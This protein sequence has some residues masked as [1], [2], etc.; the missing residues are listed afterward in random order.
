MKSLREGGAPQSVGD[1]AIENLTGVDKPFEVRVIVKR[2][3]KIDGSLIDA[4]IAGQ[5]TMISFRPGLTV[6][7]VAFQTEGLEL[8]DVQYSRL[9]DG[10]PPPR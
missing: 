4:E 3:D 7:H 2:D 5:R 9:K 10:G 6:K 1:Y 8:L